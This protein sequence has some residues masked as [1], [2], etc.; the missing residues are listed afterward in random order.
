MSLPRSNAITQ[1]VN[2]SAIDAF[3]QMVKLY[4]MDLHS[5]MIVK[6]GHVVTEVFWKPYKPEIP[7]LLNSV[8]KSFTSTAIGIA[9]H[10]NKLSLD[11]SVISFFPQYVTE[12][13]RDNMGA[14]KVKHL[15][16]MSTGHETDTTGALSQSEDWVQTFLNIPITKEPGTHF[17]YNTGAT[18]ML[19]AILHAATGEHLLDYLKPRLF[20]PLGFS[21]V[22]TETCP[23][24]IHAG[25]FG[26]SVTT[27]DIAKFGLLYLQEGMWNGQQV[28]PSW[29]IH[30]A[31]SKQIDNHHATDPDWAQGYGYQFWRSRN[32][33]YRADGMFAQ[34]S[35]IIPDHNAVVVTT[36]GVIEQQDLLNIIWNEL[37]PGLS[38]DSSTLDPSAE[39]TLSQT[40]NSCRYSVPYKPNVSSELIDRVN[41]YVYRFVPNPV[42]VNEISFQ[43]GEETTE[44]SL[45]INEQRHQLHIKHGAWTYSDLTLNGVTIP[46]ALSC[47]WRSYSKF[48]IHIKM[49]SKPY[50]DTWV[51]HFAG[52]TLMMSTERNVWVIPG[53]LSNP[54]LPTIMGFASL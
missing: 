5:F 35:I 32:N 30:E 50:A 34:F 10:E 26:M 14:M 6:N 1:G 22:T 44:V 53:A 47:S 41:Q 51:C 11:D 31:T 37:L 16:S 18:Y 33:S 2:P 46:V 3:L 49:L 52:Q 7:H 4:D 38:A 48:E 13:I 29:Y 25:G 24:G 12:Q 42:D 54:Y 43:F 9:V 20:N 19:S 17:L 23:K 21:D 36:A 15:L 45:T 40:I 27:E 39:D 8:S 28:V